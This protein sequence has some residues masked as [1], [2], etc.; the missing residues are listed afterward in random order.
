MSRGS[1]E[2]DGLDK[3]M[4]SLKRQWERIAKEAHRRQRRIHKSIGRLVR[5]R[6]VTMPPFVQWL[7][8]AE[9]Y[10][11]KLKKP[12]KSE[13]QLQRQIEELKVWS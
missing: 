11:K 9:T 4:D 10:M 12:G 13:E 1:P 2:G 8:G 5:Y 7:E 3:E 6:E